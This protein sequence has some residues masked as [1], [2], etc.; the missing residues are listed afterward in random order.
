MWARAL[1]E[2]AAVGGNTVQWWL[3]VNGSQS[4]LFEGDKVSR[5]SPQYVQI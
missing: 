1:D 5:L 2:I 4:P 3:H